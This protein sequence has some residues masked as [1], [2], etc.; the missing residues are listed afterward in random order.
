M[1]TVRSD[2]EIAG[3][4][5]SACFH[6]CENTRSIR[7][8]VFVHTEYFVYLFLHNS[9]IGNLVFHPSVST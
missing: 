5:Y 6:G 2:T 1:Y 7:V 4:K 3:F 9:C 8:V